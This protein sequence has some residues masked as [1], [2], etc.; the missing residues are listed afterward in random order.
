MA[1][2]SFLGLILVREG[3]LGSGRALVGRG[4][5]NGRRC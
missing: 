2:G 5:R 3:W 1:D 4:V